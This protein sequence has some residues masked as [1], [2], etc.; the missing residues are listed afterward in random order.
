MKYITESEVAYPTSN[1]SNRIITEC[2][3][4]YNRVD[5]VSVA[6]YT[7]KSENGEIVG[8]DTSMFDPTE[9]ANVINDVNNDGL[10]PYQ[11]LELMV[12]TDL[13]SKFN[14]SVEKYK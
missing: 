2:E 10:E 9:V 7:H 1:D 12:K 8:V 11:V 5:N 14:V 6:T 3:M 4:T 13:E